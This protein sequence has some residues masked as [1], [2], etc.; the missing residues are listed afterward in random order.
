[1]L[2]KLSRRTMGTPPFK[3]GSFAMEQRLKGSKRRTTVAVAAGIALLLFAAVALAG[4]SFK[5]GNFETGDFT[6]WTTAQSGAG[7]WFVSDKKLTPINAFNWNGPA[8]KEFAAVTDQTSFSANVL[9]RTVQVGSKTSKISMVLYY[10]NQAGVFCNPDTP[11]LDET[12]GECFQMYTVDIL[13]EGA[14]PFSID[15]ADII[16][17]VFR[18]SPSS[19]NSMSPK[20]FN[21]TL[22]KAGNVI[23]RFGEVDNQY[24]FNASVDNVTVNNGG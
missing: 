16:K 10:K 11:T 8:E 13:R 18:T 24:Y 20:T 19:P 21:V 23:L 9:Y 3:E 14:D 1:V 2:R 12:L 4:S 15:P 5:N 7:N 22:K 6:K 17:T